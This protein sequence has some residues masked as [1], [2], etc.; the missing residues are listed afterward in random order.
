[1]LYTSRT[2]KDATDPNQHSG[3]VEEDNDEESRNELDFFPMCM[4]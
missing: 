4:H 2:I 1:M 3:S